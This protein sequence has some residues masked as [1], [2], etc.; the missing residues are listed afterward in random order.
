MSQEKACD[1]NHQ[2]AVLTA[3]LE[4]EHEA[5]RTTHGLQELELRRRRQADIQRLWEELQQPW[6]LL[7]QRVDNVS[8]LPPAE[9]ITWAQSVRSM[10][11]ATLMEIDTTGVEHDADLVRFTLA[12]IHGTIFY[13]QLIKPGQAQLGTEASQRNGLAASDLVDAPHLH[14][15]WPHLCQ[16]VA[17]RY[18]V[19]FGQEWDGT[20]LKAVAKRYG[21]PQIVLIG[22][23]L[24]RL[25]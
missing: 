8:M 11:T 10:P 21:L 20:M 23:D 3:L 1:F 6:Q 12:D 25:C 17:G 5:G 22:E 18:I 14:D 24:Q 2:V 7:K 19:A 15:A 9:Q 16:A 4:Q 13:D